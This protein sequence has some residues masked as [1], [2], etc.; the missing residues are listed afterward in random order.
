METCRGTNRAGRRADRDAE[1]AIKEANIE[2][3]RRLVE[4]GNVLFEN[5]L[6]Q[7]LNFD[8]R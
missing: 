7:S 1:D 5:E 6:P 2:R 3:Y 4:E 8:F